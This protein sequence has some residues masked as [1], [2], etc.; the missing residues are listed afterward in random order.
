MTTARHNGTV[1]TAHEATIQ[2]AQVAIKVLRMGKKQ[3]TMGMFRQLPVRPIVPWWDFVEAEQ[4]GSWEEASPLRVHG[5]PW[6]HVNYWWAGTERENEAYLTE[7][8]ALQYSPGERLHLVWQQEEGL[9]RSMVYSDLPAAVMACVGPEDDY[10]TPILQARRGEMA[11][12]WR[13]TWRALAALPQLY[14][15]V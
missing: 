14:I 9:Y 13:Q 3:V 1:L 10:T 8:G 2:T 15:A 4:S 12:W 11:T 5:V 7:D 6:G